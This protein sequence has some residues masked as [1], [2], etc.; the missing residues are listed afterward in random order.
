M[1]NNKKKKPSSKKQLEDKVKR[2]IIYKGNMEE[3]CKI[4]KILGDRKL[5]ILLPDKSEVNASI[6]GR[7]RKK[8]WFKIGDVVLASYREFQNDK[9]DIIYKYNEEE[10]KKLIKELEIPEYFLD[11]ISNSLGVIEND[12][13]I[14]W[15]EYDD[16]DNKEIYNTNMKKIVSYQDISNIIESNSDLDSNYDS[17]SNFNSGEIINN[18][19]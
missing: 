13:L 1:P 8:C 9:L 18:K 17:D 11:G 15:E 6:P 16:N 19:K 10:V 7:F 5:I 2:D 14:E 3:Y 4:H 12:N